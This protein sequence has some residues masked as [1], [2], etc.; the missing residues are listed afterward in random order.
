MRTGRYYAF[1]VLAKEELPLP[2][3]LVLIEPGVNYFNAVVEDLDA[4]IR[5]LAEGKVTVQKVHPLDEID[6]E[7]SFK[8]DADGNW[9]STGDLPK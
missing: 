6:V 8:Q 4:F 5:F 2:D 7:P 9:Y 1:T 3:H